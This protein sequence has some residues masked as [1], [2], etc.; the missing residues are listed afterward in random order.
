MKKRRKTERW[1]HHRWKLLAV[2]AAMFVAAGCGDDSEPDPD[3]EGP[4][5]SAEH[6][7]Q[8]AASCDDVREHLADSVVKEAIDG[9]YGERYGVVVDEQMGNDD[10]AAEPEDGGADSGE[11]SAEPDDYTDT[12]VQEE[13]VD[14]PDMVKTDGTHIYA[15]VDG[16]LQILESWPPEDTEV[17]GRVDFDANVTP[18]S[19]FLD[20]DRAVVLSRQND[21]VRYGEPEPG[22]D[23]PNTTDDDDFEELAFDGTRVSIFDVSDEQNPELTR[24]FEVEG[25]HVD[26]RMIDGEVFL[27]TNSSLR[28][29]SYWSLMDEDDSELE[30][31]PERDWDTPQEELEQMREKAR[32]ILEDYF[33]DRVD[34]IDPEEW[35]PQHRIVEEDGDVVDDGSIYECTDL[36]LPGVNADLGV[37]NISAFDIDGG[38]ELDSTGLVARGWEVYASQ[39]NLYVAMSS[40]SWWWGPWGAGDQQNE[41]H[42]HKFQLLGDDDPKYMASGRIDGWI[43]NQFSMSEYDGYLRVATTD[44]RWEWDDDADEAVDEG[45]NHMIILKRQGDELI[46][47]GSVRDLAPTEQVHSARFMGD[48]GFMVTFFIVDPFYT[49]DLSD[50]YDPKMLGELEIP[51][52]SS[53]MH[54]IGDDHLLAIGQDG[55]DD[56]MMTGVHL[57]VFDVTDMENP[58]RTQHHT[59]STG[60]W[61]SWSEAMHDHHAFTYQP[62]TGVLAIPINIRDDDDIFNGLILFEATVDGIEE[63]GRIDHED[64][65]AKWWC[66]EQQDDSVDDCSYDANDAGWFHWRSRMRRSIMMTGENGEEYVYSLSDVGMKVNDVFDVD[67]EYASVYLRD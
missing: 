37:L 39:R 13:G 17:L 59:I 8:P 36:Y 58:E 33:H 60:S 44:N 5:S 61:S 2:G 24:Q 28:D 7:L 51:G 57:Q 64:L 48:R 21:H 47:T 38:A 4:A 66:E 40:R 42:I 45:G 16:A 67:T 50:P 32:P 22:V 56:G 11:S 9:L 25:R 54:P 49:F 20:G 46:E 43:L 52:Y 19:L 31:L 1:T 12:N 30:D 6:T 41:S 35:L 62:E 10:T 18:F 65:I 27:V 55:D 34:E 3:P 53:Y 29:L 23:S 15:I 26:A 63:I 14:E